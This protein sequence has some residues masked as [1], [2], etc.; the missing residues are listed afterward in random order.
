MRHAL[1]T[2]SNHEDYELLAQRCDELKTK[3]KVLEGNIQRVDEDLA[4]LQSGDSHFN[5]PNRSV[6]ELL[7]HAYYEGLLQNSR[8]TT[9]RKSPSFK[10]LQVGYHLLISLKSVSRR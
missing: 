8:P 4:A 9:L 5:I 3:L 10:G 6:L 1:I 2:A 7:V